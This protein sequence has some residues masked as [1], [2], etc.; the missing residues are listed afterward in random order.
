MFSFIVK[1]QNDVYDPIILSD[2]SEFWDNDPIYRYVE[3]MP[4][5]PGGTKALHEYIIKQ[6][7][8]PPE[9]KKKGIQGTV[10]LN[11]IVMKDGSIGNVYVVKGVD[12]LL[13]IEAIRV[14]KN[15]PRFI[16]GKEND[17]KVNVILAIPVKFL[18]DK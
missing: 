1:A 10:Y 4:K 2:T 6:I 14:I 13:D 18:L 12:N 9:A 8:Y 15:L 3:E 17:E 5:F 11:F 16:P 7:I